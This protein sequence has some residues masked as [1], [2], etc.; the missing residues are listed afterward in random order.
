MRTANISLHL[1]L[2]N[3]LEYERRRQ[4]DG[5]NNKRSFLRFEVF[6][7]NKLNKI[8]GNQGF[9]DIKTLM[10]ETEMILE[11]LVLS[12]TKRRG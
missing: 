6:A 5:Q 1:I 8:S 10:M 12:V 4:T 9:D 2:F 7:A 3:G 11:T